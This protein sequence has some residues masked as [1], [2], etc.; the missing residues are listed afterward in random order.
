MGP[1]RETMST[2]ASYPAGMHQWILLSPQTERLCVPS[3]SA[4]SLQSRCRCR[5][6]WRRIVFLRARLRTVNLLMAL[7]RLHVRAA[8]AERG[9]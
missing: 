3:Q 1:G 6:R 8:R 5:I 4:L 7:Q 9:R 2:F